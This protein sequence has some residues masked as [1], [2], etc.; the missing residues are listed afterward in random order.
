MMQMLNN[1]FARFA[2]AATIIWSVSGIGKPA[3]AQPLKSCTSVCAS[4]MLTDTPTWQIA[5]RPM[6]SSSFTDISGVY[7]ETQIL[8][9]AALGVLDTSNPEFQ[10]L[11]PVTRSEFVQWLV[12]TYNELHPNPIRLPAITTAPFPDVPA[13]HSQAAYI[14]A[15]R[16]AGFL[17]GFDDGRF[18]PDAP[19]TREQMIVLK[20]FMDSTAR[21]RGSRK[22]ESL[23]NYL[24][25]TRG[26][27]DAD[28]I[29][30]Q[31]LWYIAFDVGNGASF[32]NFERV[33]GRTDLFR[34]QAPVTRAEAAVLISQFRRGIT[35]ERELQ[36]RQR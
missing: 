26:F 11:R 17:V 19:L 5:S 1:R 20:T 36:R 34:P 22:P 13:T 29:S 2:A 28:R 4:R 30:E 12:Q 27:T 14:Q 8:Q 21:D 7:G 6:S 10:P 32:R 25:R 15:A 9:L 31:Y 23:R 16:D 35:V 3:E 18:Q 24:S 33:Y